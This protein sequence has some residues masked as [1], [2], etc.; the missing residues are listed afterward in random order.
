MSVF[1]CHS[2]ILSDILFMKKCDIG[3]KGCPEK[4]KI[5]CFLKVIVV[6]VS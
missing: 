3:D 6:I 1:E 4:E 2:F 5:K